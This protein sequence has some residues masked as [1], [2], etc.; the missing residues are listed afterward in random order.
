[1][2]AGSKMAIAAKKQQP[3]LGAE[4]ERLRGDL[5]AFLDDKVAALKATRDGAGLPVEML[6][7]QIV[8][9]SNCLC[10][11]VQRLIDEERK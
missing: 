8:G 7:R 1:M 9:E 10:Q 2:M 5:L 6:K 4:I 11:I 3:D